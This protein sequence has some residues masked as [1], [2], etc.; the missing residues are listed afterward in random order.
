MSH[1][2]CTFAGQDSE[3]ISVS[4]VVENKAS[5]YVGVRTMTGALAVAFWTM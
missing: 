3:D 2:I 5:S 4:L 1:S